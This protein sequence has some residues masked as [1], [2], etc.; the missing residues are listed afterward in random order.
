MESF[1]H[2][3]SKL[4]AALKKVK[5]EL[6]SFHEQLVSFASII[7]FTDEKKIWNTNLFQYLNNIG[8]VA[9]WK[10]QL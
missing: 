5:S 10:A 1:L 8:A 3:A 9:S 6:L 7:V 4:S 2:Y